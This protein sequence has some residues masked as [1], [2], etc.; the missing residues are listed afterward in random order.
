LAAGQGKADACLRQISK[1]I[2]DF[3]DHGTLIGTIRLRNLAG[4]P[5]AA[6]VAA[7]AGWYILSAQAQALL[8]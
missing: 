1:I 7:V 8:F 6:V 2:Y 5:R 3:R 4:N